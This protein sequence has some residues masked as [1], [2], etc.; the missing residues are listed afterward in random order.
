MWN[1]VTMKVDYN[2]ALLLANQANVDVQFIGHNGSRLPYY[3]TVSVSKSLVYGFTCVVMTIV[4]WLCRT[5][6]MAISPSIWQQR[7]LKVNTLFATIRKQELH[8]CD[9][10]STE[11]SVS[12]ESC[13]DIV[14]HVLHIWLQ[15]VFTLQ[16]TWWSMKRL[17]QDDTWK[18]I[19][20]ST[21]SLGT[22]AMSFLLKS[23][24]S[25]QVG[26]NEA[27]VDRLLCCSHNCNKTY[28]FLLY[29]LLNVSLQ[30]LS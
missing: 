7:S 27:T 24:K 13:T 17:E 29:I 10:V 21:K 8:G 14:G 23:V 18:D 2:A 16:I 1:V 4:V 5:C 9:T 6:Q 28:N 3:I 22:N 26:S 12:R 30:V 20:S 25:R 11:V 15:I 19:S